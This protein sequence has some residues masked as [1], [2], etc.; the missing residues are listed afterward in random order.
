MRT[1]EITYRYGGVDE[2]VRPRPLDADSA[3]SRLDAGNR[4]FAALLG[5]LAADNTIARRVVEVDPRDLGLDPGSNEAPRQRP[6]AA[7]IGCSDAQ[8]PIEL[9]FNEGPNDLFVIR[10]AG[11]G[12]GGDVLGSLKYAVEHL[13]G[14]LRLVVVLA[15]SGCG[16]ITAAVDVFLEPAGYLTLATQ[17]ALRNILDRQLIV[18]Q[19][20]AKTL[21]TAL[22]PDVTRRPGYREALI[23]TSIVLNA[24]LTAHTV[25]QEIGR[26]VSSSLQA[27]YGV[28]LLQTREVWTPRAGVEESTGLAAP[29]TDAASFRSFGEAVMKSPRIA[30]LLRA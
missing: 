9:I 24:A 21:A 22:G 18:V 16:A 10:V 7:V 13:S 4:E 26:G 28:Y 27:V 2:V 3:R 15:H 25:Q 12:L 30:S 5:G 29:P 14:S 11:N 20:C 1:V 8:V 17:H 19:A 6:F 23:E